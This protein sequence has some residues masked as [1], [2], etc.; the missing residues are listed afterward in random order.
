MSSPGL[1][2]LVTPAELRCT[3]RGVWPSS[4]LSVTACETN[5]VA[6]IQ[7]H[8]QEIRKRT[9]SGNVTEK[10]RR[11]KT[12]FYKSKLQRKGIKKS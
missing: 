10:N 1:P 11:K 4:P 5:K 7:T 9:C 12:I 8:K 3:K 2:G 6:K